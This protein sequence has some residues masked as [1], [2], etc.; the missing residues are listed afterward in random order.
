M[1]LAVVALAAWRADG[2][3]AGLDSL[4]AMVLAA[5]LPLT[6]GYD[7]AGSSYGQG[8]TST[9][10]T[11]AASNASVRAVLDLS[12]HATGIIAV[13]AVLGAARRHR[14]G[15]RAGPPSALAWALAGAEFLAPAEQARIHTLTSLFKHVGYGAWFAC[16]MAGYLLAELPSLL[17]RLARL[18]R[19][20][21][22]G[23][24]GPV[25]GGPGIGRRRRPS[26]RGRAGRCWPAPRRAPRP[27]WRP[28]SSA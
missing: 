1:V 14:P 16:V 3:K 7:L 15:G 6:I 25:P 12:A 8:I 11:R 24:A 10:L 9:T 18:A 26:G 19:P 4:G 21:P 2:R 13:L 5:A 22:A 23:P 28:G 20:G 17:A 27:C